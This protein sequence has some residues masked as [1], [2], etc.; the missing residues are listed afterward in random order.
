ME[1]GRVWHVLNN[2][3]HRKYDRNEGILKMQWHQLHNQTSYDHNVE[4]NPQPDEIWSQWRRK[5]TGRWDMIIIKKKIHSQ[6]SYNCNEERDPEKS[7]NIKLQTRTNIQWKTKEQSTEDP[8]QRSQAR[9]NVS[10]NL[11]ILV[12]FLFLPSVLDLHRK[13]TLKMG[14]SLAF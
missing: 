2:Q 12:C 7:R 1:D 13:F 3:S 5:S 11:I 4:E 9:A 6:K 14:K 8:I 10:R